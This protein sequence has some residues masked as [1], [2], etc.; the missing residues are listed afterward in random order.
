ML[1]S[2][3]NL[4][5]CILSKEKEVWKSFEVMYHQRATAIAN[6]DFSLSSAVK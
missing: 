2:F 5:L 6:P 1:N 4:L 3:A